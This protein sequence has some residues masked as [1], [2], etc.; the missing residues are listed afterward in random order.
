MLAVGSMTVE[1]QLVLEATGTE[2][3]AEALVPRRTYWDRSF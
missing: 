3:V 2:C 1:A